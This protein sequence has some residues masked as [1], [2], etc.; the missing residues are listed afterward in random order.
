MNKKELLENEQLALCEGD[1][2]FVTS[3]KL[4]GP[5]DI[6]MSALNHL[7]TKSAITLTAHEKSV[8]LVICAEKA[9]EA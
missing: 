1:A 2:L 3:G 5:D 9:K 6:E 4:E 7:V 8:V